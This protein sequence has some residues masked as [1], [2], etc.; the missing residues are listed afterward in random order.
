MCKQYRYTNNSDS[1]TEWEVPPTS[2]K[3]QVIWFDQLC[4]SKI[5]SS[6]A[7]LTAGFCRR[8]HDILSAFQ[9]PIFTKFGHGMRIHVT[10]VLS[11]SI[12][13]NFV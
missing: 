13:A 2:W 1:K 10:R 8:N 7:S 3:T 6:D 4:E 5:G 9:R 12:L 11:E